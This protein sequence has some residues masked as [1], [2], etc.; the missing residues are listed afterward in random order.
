MI[1]KIEKI[2]PN[3]EFNFPEFVMSHLLDLF[4]TYCKGKEIQIHE[5]Q[6]AYD[7]SVKTSNLLR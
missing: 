3:L 4:S 1:N 5:G 7:L 2:G 6:I